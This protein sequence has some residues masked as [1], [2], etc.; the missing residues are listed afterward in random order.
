M[1]DSVI[2][3]DTTQ[4]EWPIIRERLLNRIKQTF[5]TAP[6][7]MAPA[8]PEF[9]ELERYTSHGLVHIK[10]LYHVFDDFWNEAILV[11][12]NN[13]EEMKPAPAV[14]TIH[15]TNNTCGKY[16]V[17]DVPNARKNRAYAIELAKRGFVTISP[18]QYGFGSL[19]EDP[20]YS[21]KFERF[22]NDYPEW[23]LMSRRLLDAIRAVDVLCQL[24]YVK[25]DGFGVMGN[26]L[27]GCASMYLAAF[28]E[29]IKAAVLSTGVSPSATNIYRSVKGQD[30]ITP[31]VVNEMR[32]DGI[33]P[34]DLHEILALC[35]PRAVLCLEPF[36]DPFNPFTETTFDCV[37][38]AW[39]VYNLLEAPQKLSIFVHGDGHDT[40]NDV[41][42][43]AY[44]W[45]ARFLN[46]Q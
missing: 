32:R 33:P 6:V 19:M 42:D 8:K 36:N 7:S 45:L 12:P 23:S 46:E 21:Q 11:L 3:K 43:F 30:W 44:N 20:A 29:R 35:A 28:D 15:G 5:G 41:R 16:G 25:K 9:K 31:Q 10:I 22:Y 34:W 24:D 40:V 27:G 38:S 17:L 39:Q 26:S 4:A 1:I 2:L 18:D 13:L 37:R 14:V